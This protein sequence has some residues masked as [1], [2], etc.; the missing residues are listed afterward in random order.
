MPVGGGIPLLSPARVGIFEQERA[1]K[2]EV[3]GRNYLTAKNAESAEIY[4]F[5]ISAFFAVKWFSSSPFPP[6]PPV[7]DSGLKVYIRVSICYP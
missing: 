1:E 2:A 5:V 6:F 7:Q 4:F 3:G